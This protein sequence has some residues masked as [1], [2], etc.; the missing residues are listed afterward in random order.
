[1][2]QLEY[3]FVL[4]SCEIDV[5]KEFTCKIKEIDEIKEVCKV[6]GIYDFLIKIDY[7]TRDKIHQTI[8]EKI[9]KMDKIKTTISLMTTP[10]PTK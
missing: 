2:I 1:M 9:C 7:T 3:A 6:M 10:D 5:E 8:A 4:L